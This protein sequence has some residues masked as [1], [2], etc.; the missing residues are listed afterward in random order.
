MQFSGAFTIGDVDSN[1]SKLRRTKQ[2][3]SY[4]TPKAIVQ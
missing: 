1:I 3:N 2:W 4:L